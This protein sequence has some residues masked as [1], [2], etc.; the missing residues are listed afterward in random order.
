M[1]IVD[2]IEQGSDE[3][4]EARRA[5]PTA[6]CFG[7]IITPT[8]SKSTQAKDYM[9]R[10]LY[11][12]WTGKT[13]EGF[14]SEW[15]LRGQEMEED[16]RNM[17]QFIKSSEVRKVGI[18]Y[19]DDRKLVACS[20]DGLLD[21][22]GQEIK[23]PAAHTHVGYMLGG[24]KIPNLYIPQAQGGMYVTGFDK[25]DFMSYHPDMKPLLVTVYRD[26]EYINKMDKL[27]SAFIDEMLDKRER[28]SK[29]REAA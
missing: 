21:D 25:W 13:E 6:S 26:D 24:N 1:I 10:L 29:I 23:C 28:L 7:K 2:D 12:W 22:R 19:K 11:E 17:Y 27:I 3:W 20:P 15:M 8:G 9:N 16:A 4:F 14:K 5:I 18:V